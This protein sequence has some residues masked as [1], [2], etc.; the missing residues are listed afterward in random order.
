MGERERAFLK[1]FGEPNNKNIFPLELNS[2]RPILI[3]V[4][5]HCFG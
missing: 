4:K 3:K 5:G 1:G 2:Y